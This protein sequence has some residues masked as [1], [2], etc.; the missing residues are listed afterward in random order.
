MKEIDFLPD[1]YKSSRRRQLSYHSQV[2]GLI[3]VFVVMLVWNFFDA[4]SISRA[5]A[6]LAREAARQA[7]AESASREFA[8]IKSKVMKLQKKAESIREI[9][10]RI[11]VGNV[12]AELSF[13]IDEKIV[14]SRLEFIAERFADGQEGKRSV[15]SAVRLAGGKSAGSRTSP[16]GGVRFKVVIAGVAS[17][18]SDVAGLICRLEDS[19]YFRLVYP[20][21]SRNK[22]MRG[23]TGLGRENFQV[24]EF[25]I[26]CYLANYKELIID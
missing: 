17:D 5:T 3:G 1:W 19:P 18:A 14:L 16:L 23:G 8:G 24:S 4:H 13:L 7:E 15:G 25:E 6:A 20:S 21:F 26:S 22:E 12:L 2:V 11:D 9:D 10:S